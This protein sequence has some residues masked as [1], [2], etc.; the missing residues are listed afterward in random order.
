MKKRQSKSRRMIKIMPFGLVKKVMVKAVRKKMEKLPPEHKELFESLADVMLNML[1][2]EYELHMIDM[3][4]DCGN[5]LNISKKDF[6]ATP[7]NAVNK[8]SQI[9]LNV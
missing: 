8:F 6:K 3:L 1:T 9:K 4:I 2:K 7:H 5:H